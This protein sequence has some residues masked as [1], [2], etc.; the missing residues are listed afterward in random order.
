MIGRLQTILVVLAVGAFA[1]H[2][3]AALISDFAD[4]S[5]RNS[6]GALVLPGRLY[7]PPEAAATPATPR[8]LIL[9][10][11]GAGEAGTNNSAQVNGNIDN[12]LAEA[13]RRG[14]YLYAPQSPGAWSDLTLTGRVMSMVDRALAE[15][16]VDVN[17]LYVTGL[18]NGGGGTWNILSRY[19]ERFAAGV[20][21][22][23][24]TPASDFAPAKLVHQAIAAFH[25]RNDGTVAVGTSRTVVNR[26]LSA[27]A[28]TAPLYPSLASAPDFFYDAPGL[29]LHY[30]ELRTGGHGI[31]GTVYNTPALY[32]WMFA[33]TLAVPEP[34]ALL[35][36]A[37]ACLG[38]GTIRRYRRIS[39]R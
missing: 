26:I 16:H 38:L 12:L 15:Q 17:R 36:A 20:P 14:A 21:I 9:F 22:C 10:L 4:F 13:K 27:A 24:V 30:V 6:R 11:H 2:S 5:L 1:A 25:A 7:I 23:G 29:D 19:G 31:W 33:H 28:L 39:L 32:D 3:Q 8:P 37:F 34:G 35:V 18:S